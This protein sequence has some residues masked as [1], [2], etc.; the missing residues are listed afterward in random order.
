[1]VF[2]TSLNICDAVCKQQLDFLLLFIHFVSQPFAPTRKVMDMND[3][4]TVAS[5][6]HLVLILISCIA[7]HHFEC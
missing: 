7:A 1:M 5:R 6:S 3:L 2:V 4:N